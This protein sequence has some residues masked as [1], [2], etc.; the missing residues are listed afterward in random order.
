MKTSEMERIQPEKLR[1]QCI[2]QLITIEILKLES[3]IYI[4]KKRIQIIIKIW[5]II[6]KEFTDLKMFIYTHQINSELA[7]FHMI[8]TEAK[9]NINCNVKCHKN[10]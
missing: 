2:S 7:V 8:I 5:I 4:F 6:V 1:N 9:N 3:I 10:N